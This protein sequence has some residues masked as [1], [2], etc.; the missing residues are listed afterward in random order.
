MDNGLPVIVEDGVAKLTDRSAFAGSVATCDLLIRTM[1]SLAEVPLHDAVYMLTE[2]P[3]R[4]MGWTDRGRIAPGH[5]ADF[6]V[7]DREINVTKT[8]VADRVIHG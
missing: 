5:R 7:F 1:V 4:I 3:A 6:T 8:I 2:T